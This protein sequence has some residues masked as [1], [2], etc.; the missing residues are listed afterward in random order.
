MPV[1]FTR[2]KQLLLRINFYRNS[3]IKFG[4]ILNTS[5]TID[6]D[7]IVEEGT[8]ISPGTNIAGNVH[9]GKYCWIG[10]GSKIIQNIRIGDNVTVGGGSLVLKD[11]PSNLKVFGSP[12]NVIKDN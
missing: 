1:S 8:H 10:I 7:S 11:I 9:I 2:E 4:S 6:H 3:K 5:C 12:I